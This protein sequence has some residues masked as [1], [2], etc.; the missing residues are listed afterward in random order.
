M[1]PFLG[2][3]DPFPPV[4][5]ARR[6]LGGLL[7]IGAD[8]APDRLLDAYLRGIFPWGTY[9]GQAL[10]YSPDPRMILF[11]EEFRLSASL[12]KTLRTGHYEVRLDSDFPA[13]IAACA[14]MPRP[15]QDGTWISPPMMDAYIRL[16]ELGWAHSVEVYAEGNLIGGLYGLAI[17]RMFYGESMFARRS[18]ASKIA[19]AHLVRYLLAH[20]FGLIDCQ[21]RTEHLAS[22]GAREI[23]RHAFLDR[24]QALTCGER[25]R[26]A[27][28]LDQPGSTW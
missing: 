16:H 21:M 6:E 8:L 3:L 24:L 11:P 14:A 7:A 19:F 15:G 2:P 20:D 17:G 18:N 27:W 23:P 22:L 10:W 13:V 25:A 4:E 12:R 9:E 26:A 1:L 5:S 28:R